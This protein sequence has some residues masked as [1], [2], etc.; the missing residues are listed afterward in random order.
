MTHPNPGGGGVKKIMD[1]FHILGHKQSNFFLLA[2]NLKELPTSSTHPNL[3][4][5]MVIG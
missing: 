1:F 2:E 5:L 4:I 3:H